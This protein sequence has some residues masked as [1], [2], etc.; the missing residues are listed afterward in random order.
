VKYT[1]KLKKGLREKLLC[2]EC[3]QFLNDE[4][5]KYFYTFW[6]KGKAIPP[7]W[8]G[9][10]IRISGIDYAKFK[11]FHLSVLFRAGISKLPTFEYVTLGAH[12]ERLKDMILSKNPGLPNRYH[13]YAYAVIKDDN[14][15]VNQLITQPIQSRFDGHIVYSLIYSGCMWNYMVSSDP[16][17][18]LVS[19]SFILN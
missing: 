14:S 4:Y 15:V 7:K 9:G 16:S 3:E 1:Q 8:Y 17:P 18:R 5:E 12:E 13:I 10:K 2:D 11:L 19:Y 6:V